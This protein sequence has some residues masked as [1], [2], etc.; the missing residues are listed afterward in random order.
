MAKSKTSTKLSS[1]TRSGSATKPASAGTVTARRSPG[2]PRAELADQA[3][4]HDRIAR[5]AYEIWQR[6]GRPDGQDMDHWLQ[7]E[8]ELKRSD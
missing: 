5:R 2:R 1:S 3:A 8:R 6:E 7:A 4:D